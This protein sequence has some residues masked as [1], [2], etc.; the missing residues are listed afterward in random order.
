MEG[1]YRVDESVGFYLNKVISMRDAFLFVAK[2][3]KT[4]FV[5]ENLRLRRLLQ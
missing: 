2:N 3:R 4:L 1:G 5:R